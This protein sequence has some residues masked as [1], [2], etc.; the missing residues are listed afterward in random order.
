MKREREQ[1]REEWIRRTET[2]GKE[3]GRRET[4]S[5]GLVNERW[6]TVC[7]F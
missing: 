3:K 6:R 1:R 5:E 7:E 4:Y 2:R